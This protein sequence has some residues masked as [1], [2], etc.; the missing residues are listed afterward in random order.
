MGKG[1]IAAALWDRIGVSGLLSCV[2]T[3]V[4]ASPSDVQLFRSPWVRR[5]DGAGAPVLA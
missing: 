5:P 1:G 2:K 3:A 4:D